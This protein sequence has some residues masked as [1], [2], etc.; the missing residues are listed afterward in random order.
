MKVYD[1]MSE[2][3]DLIYSDDID[4][5]FYIREAKNARGP[6]LEV[7][8]GTGRIL[9]ALMREGIDATGIDYSKG[10]LGRLREKAKAAG[11]MP[12][13]VHADMRDF[14]LGKT[15]NLIIVPYRSFL[16]LRDDQSRKMA[17]ATFR[18]HLSPNGRLILHTYNPSKEELA[19]Q[20]GYHA[21]DHEDHVAPDG[22]KYSLDWFLDYE[23]AGRIGHYKI[24]MT[25]EGRDAREFLM[26]LGFIQPR[27][28]EALLKAAGF[29]N[30][31]SYCGFNYS[32]MNDACK[33][34]LWTADG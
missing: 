30:V 21:F 2:Y 32:M 19:M 34:V 25:A 8:C 27:D 22:R 33:E 14:S 17:L 7:A 5:G 13:A 3:Y 12:N 26:D 31:K 23:P 10:M 29:R 4:L 6:V 24:V 1:E 16:H 11:L 28:M 15:F 18:R 9:L 20:G